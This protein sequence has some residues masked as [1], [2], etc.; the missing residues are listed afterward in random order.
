[1]PFHAWIT[2]MKRLNS[3]LSSFLPY[4]DVE[5]MEIRRITNKEISNSSTATEFYDPFRTIYSEV[6]FHLFRYDVELN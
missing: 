3:Y 1:M 2:K 5:C 4:F 6:E